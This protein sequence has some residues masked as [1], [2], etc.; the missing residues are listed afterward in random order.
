M[1]NILL[2]FFNDPN[3]NDPVL[4]RLNELQGVSA[5]SVFKSVGLVGRVLRKIH[6]SKTWHGGAIWFGEWKKKLSQYDVVVCIASQYSPNVLRWIHSQFKNVRLINYFWDCIEISG[7]PVVHGDCFENWSFNRREAELYGFRYNPQF[8][9]ENI[10]LPQSKI[11]YDIAFVGADRNGLW[12]TRA[13]MVQKCYEQF[14]RNN[15]KSVIWFVSKSEIVD[16]QI[17]KNTFLNNH[18]YYELL[19]KSKALLDLVEP[20]CEWSTLRP[21]LALSNGK[22]LITND[23]TILSKK[24]YSKDKVFVLGVDDLSDLKYFLDDRHMELDKENKYSYYEAE[25]WVKR[26]YI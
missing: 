24:Y 22:K 14:K 25:N 8:Y 23:R 4:D 20:G 16:P 26:F 21:L 3:S 19:G 2:L 1:E 9:C 13:E 7:Y 17:R 18:E 12:K 5:V 11:E 10:K 15:L 6:L